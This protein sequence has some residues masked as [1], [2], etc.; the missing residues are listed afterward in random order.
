[1]HVFNSEHRDYSFLIRKIKTIIQYQFGLTS[2]DAQTICSKVSNIKLSRKTRRIRH[3][4]KNNQILFTL[5][6]NDG[7][8]V[9]HVEGARLILKHSKYPKNRIAVFN[10]IGEII[11]QGKTLFAKHVKDLDSNIKPG[12]EVIIVNEDDELLALGKSLLTSREIIDLNYGIAVKVR[13]G[14]N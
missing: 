2:Q 13:R 3:V 7:F 8:M 4:E 9:L 11:S 10:D 6:P 12:S 5:R 14:I 1:M